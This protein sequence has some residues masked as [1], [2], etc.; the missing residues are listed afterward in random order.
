MLEPLTS[1]AHAYTVRKIIPWLLVRPSVPSHTFFL[2]PAL[3][4]YQHGGDT[5]QPIACDHF[6]GGTGSW[7]D[8]G[9]LF[10]FRWVAWTGVIRMDSTGPSRAQVRACHLTGSTSAWRSFRLLLSE[11]NMLGILPGR[12]RCSLLSNLKIMLIVADWWSSSNDEP[13]LIPISVSRAEAGKA[14]ILDGACP[15]Q[16]K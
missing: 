8:I 6:L 15:P 11:K 14:Q 2:I 7:R 5:L 13:L 3:Y 4:R 10:D 1:C 9:T 16:Y 12:T